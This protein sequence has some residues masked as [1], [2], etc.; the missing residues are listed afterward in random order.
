MLTSRIDA[1]DLK[2]RTIALKMQTGAPLTQKELRRF[3][4]RQGIE[5]QYANSNDH[6]FKGKLSGLFG[7]DMSPRAQM[8]FAAA[9]S[10]S[11]GTLDGRYGDF[12]FGQQFNRASALNEHKR[13]ELGLEGQRLSNTGQFLSNTGQRL[14]ND[15]QGFANQ[16]AQMDLN[17][18]RGTWDEDKEQW[19]GGLD[20]LKLRGARANTRSAELAAEMNGY[21]ADALRDDF[22][23]GAYKKRVAEQDRT[24]KLE[25]D[26]ATLKIGNAQA[27]NAAAANKRKAL[28]LYNEFSR[29]NEGKPLTDAQIAEIAKFDPEAARRI[30]DE[31]SKPLEFKEYGNYVQNPYTLESIPKKIEGK[32][33]SGVV[34]VVDNPDYLR[35][36]ALNDAGYFHKYQTQQSLEDAFKNGEIPKEVYVDVARFRKWPTGNSVRSM[37][38]EQALAAYKEGRISKEELAAIRNNY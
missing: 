37:T 13:Q 6:L 1:P 34:A 12:K 14:R 2:L 17:L 16:G 25:N 32:N 8:N 4:V 7:L 33:A 10:A 22:S 36:M 29:H 26:A 5:Q 11:L 3:A 31:R 21:K 18:R 38:P 19:V 30:L 28:G 35:L 27:A 23:S 20:D 24:R 9:K 15:F